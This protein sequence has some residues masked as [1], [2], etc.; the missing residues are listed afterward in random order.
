MPEAERIERPW[1]QFIF[2]HYRIIYRV[3]GNRVSVLRVVDGARL[4]SQSFFDR[5][6]GH[7]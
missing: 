6:A 3:D 7:D 2:G 4:L 5:L 1:R